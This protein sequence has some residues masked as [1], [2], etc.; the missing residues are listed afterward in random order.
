MHASPHPTIITIHLPLK[1]K[2]TH[3]AG[4]CVATNPAGR[5]KVGSGVFIFSVLIPFFCNIMDVTVQD[6]QTI[7]D[8]YGGC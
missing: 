1:E 5:V 2:K 8:L 4:L 3:R 6:Q 7:D